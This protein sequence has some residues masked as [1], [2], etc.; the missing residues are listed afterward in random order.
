MI[1]FIFKDKN[2]RIFMQIEKILFIIILILTTLS[3]TI[4]EENG[5]K[6]GNSRLSVGLYGEKHYATSSSELD[7]KFDGSYGRF[8]S[9][10]S[11]VLLKIR[12]TTDLTY[13]AY[14]IDI[15]YS[16][17]LFKQPTLTPYVG[18]EVGISGD[19][20]I[21]S[22]KIINEEGL[23]I[24]FHK[25]FTENIALTPEVGI[26]FTD[27]TEISENYFNIYLTYFFN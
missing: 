17:Y 19:T 14:K 15:G 25:F 13:H 12:D 6:E 22:T 2:R 18:L 1:K 5:I 8:L 20:Q 4:I 9:D 7:I 16:Y 11:E 24:G 21:D 26:E 23:Y 27:L 3:S 10:N